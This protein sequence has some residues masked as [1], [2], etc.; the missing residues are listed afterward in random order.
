MTNN[1]DT[2]TL[3]FKNYMI[4]FL[5]KELFARDQVLILHQRQLARWAQDPDMVDQLPACEAQV[6]TERA[7]R[8]AINVCLQEARAKIEELEGPDLPDLARRAASARNYLYEATMGDYSIGSI[9]R[10]EH[11]RDDIKVRL[12]ARE[13]TLDEVTAWDETKGCYIATR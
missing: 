1:T 3:S 10:G 6:K 4:A 13:L 5:E 8:D 2:Q 12:A 9:T 11:I 7:A